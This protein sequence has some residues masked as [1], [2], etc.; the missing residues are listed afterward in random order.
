MAKR[1][2]SRRVCS[3]IR[4]AT[5][6]R[7]REAKARRREARIAAGWTPEPKFARWFPMEIGFRDRSSGEVA[8]T[9]LRSVRQAAR[10]S[11]RMLREWSA[12]PAQWRRR[13]AAESAHK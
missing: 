12:T 10:L 8:W 5:L 4:L 3:K 2:H 7:M 11:S 1:T 6:A 9:E 13:G